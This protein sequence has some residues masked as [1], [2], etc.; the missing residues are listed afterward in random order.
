LITLGIVH[1]RGGSKRLPKKNIRLLN[2]IPLVGYICR[3]AIQAKMLDVV[4]I[5]SDHK[6][7]ISIAK[8]FGVDAPFV[9]PDAISRNCP[10]ELV[11][12]HA[13]Q[14]MREK[15]DMQIDLAVTLQPTTPFCLPSDIDSVIQVVKGNPSFSSA[16][17]TSVIQERPEWMFSLSQNLIARPFL[18]V[19]PSGRKGISQEL[20]KL[21]YP[22]GG[23]YVTRVNALFS[24][25]SIITQDS[26]IHIMPQENSVDI[27][28]LI[29]FQFAEFL[30]REKIVQLPHMEETG[31]LTSRAKR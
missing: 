23:V 16:F 10:S 4:I 15:F 20:P 14:F 17:S 13:V 8:E 1:A 11:T 30:L 2:N 28:E 29:D 22:N 6:A 19:V 25:N 3:A 26:G 24:E 21:Y 31:T 5:S 27:D 9:R 12:Q 7:T 18:G